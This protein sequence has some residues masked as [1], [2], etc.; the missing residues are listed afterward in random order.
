M[1]AIGALWTDG[2]D[3]S[4]HHVATEVW[5]LSNDT[6][7]APQ[8]YVVCNASGEDP[9]CSDSVPAWKWVMV[10][11]AVCSIMLA[12]A[13]DSPPQYYMGVHNDNCGH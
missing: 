12:A 8:K 2:T 3:D 4:F 9:S 10:D 5:D 6:V 1:S 13:S 11:H 7:G